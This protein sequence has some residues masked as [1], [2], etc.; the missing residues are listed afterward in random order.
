[1]CKA[2]AKKTIEVSD[3][4]LKVSALLY[5]NHTPVNRRPNESL[6]VTIPMFNAVQNVQR[7]NSEPLSYNTREAWLYLC[8][9]AGVEC[10]SEWF[11]KRLL[12]VRIAS[13]DKATTQEKN[14]VEMTREAVKT[15]MTTTPEIN[16]EILKNLNAYI[17]TKG[18]DVEHVKKILREKSFSQQHIDAYVEASDYVLPGSDVVF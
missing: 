14:A 8:E 7:E 13:R 10:E 4:E 17:N 5:S 16:A 3:D 1:M 9:K 18:S 6:H 12:S 2:K 15:D 11:D